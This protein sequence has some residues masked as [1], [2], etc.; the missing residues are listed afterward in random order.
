METNKYI[1]RLST[2][3]DMMETELSV[4]ATKFE[5]ETA[6]DE[7]KRNASFPCRIQLGVFQGEVLKTKDLNGFVWKNV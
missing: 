4:Y 5:A 2:Y 1:I 3:K 6:F 7:M